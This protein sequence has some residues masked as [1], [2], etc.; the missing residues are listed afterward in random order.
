MS[1]QRVAKLSAVAVAAVG[2]LSGCFWSQPGFRPARTR[3]NPNETVLTAASM[4][5]LHE[6][7]SAEFPNAAPSEI[8]TDG[9]RLYMTT[10]FV[11]AGKLGVAVE[12][13][14]PG[15]GQQLWSQTLSQPTVGRPLGVAVS[16]DHL[17]LAY[18][19]GGADPNC[20]TAASLDPATG[21]VLHSAPSG[22]PASPMV[23][24]GST[25]ARLVKDTCSTTL[26]TLVVEDRDTMATLWTAPVGPVAGAEGDLVVA[27]GRI[28]VS[29]GSSLSAFALGGCGAST[30]PPLW[31]KNTGST[32]TKLWGRAPDGTLVV[33]S[34][35]TL[36]P[37]DPNIPGDPGSFFSVVSALDGGTGN[38]VRRSEIHGDHAPDDP[39]EQANVNGVVIAGD[40]LGVTATRSTAT[41]F[42]S[43]HDLV[44]IPSTGCGQA[45]CAA[46]WSAPLGG[47]GQQVSGA[48]EVIYLLVG[49]PATG[50]GQL[51]AFAR[52]GCGAAVCSALTSVPLEGGPEHLSISAGRVFVVTFGPTGR[53]LHAFG[54][55]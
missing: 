34:V 10:S 52:D 2:S 3:Y 30:C 43:S 33:S 48:G 44:A 16:G 5:D 39:S 9:S 51:E 38:S 20:A 31:T 14:D 46:A 4:A 7:W 42:V 41:P 26:S 21:A 6:K 22:L 11:A 23:T 36:R 32:S 49:D 15:S 18:N 19:N 50:L 8:V 45:V 13:R 35:V 28:Y 55:G 17:A 53:T 27:D 40:T 1:V 25:V 24:S 47:E 29:T 37:P 54:V 12:A